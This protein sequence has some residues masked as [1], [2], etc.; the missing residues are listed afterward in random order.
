MRDFKRVRKGIHA[1][2]KNGNYSRADTF[3]YQEGTKCLLKRH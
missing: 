1:E 3:V 2:I